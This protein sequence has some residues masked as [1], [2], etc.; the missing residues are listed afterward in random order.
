[1]EYKAHPEYGKF[2]DVNDEVL[3]GLD[4]DTDENG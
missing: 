1:M 2:E 4:S 3:E